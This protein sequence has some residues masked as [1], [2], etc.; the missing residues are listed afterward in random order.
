MN[1]VKGISHTTPVRESRRGQLEEHM[2]VQEILRT[3][4]MTALLHRDL[5]D[6]RSGIVTK[7]RPESSVCFVRRTIMTEPTPHGS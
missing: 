1:H 5:L 6:Q 7:H 3:G 4:I 2:S